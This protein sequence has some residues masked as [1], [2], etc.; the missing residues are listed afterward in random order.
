[1]GRHLGVLSD[2]LDGKEGL[3]A[4]GRI[5]LVGKLL[6]QGFDG[7]A[8]GASHVSFRIVEILVGRMKWAAKKICRVN[9]VLAAT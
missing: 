7:P 1:M 2:S 8:D 9:C 6:L 3:L 4:D 5:L